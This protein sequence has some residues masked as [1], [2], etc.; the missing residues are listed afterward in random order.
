MDLRLYSRVI[1]RFRYLVLGGL[2]V[3]FALAF[4]SFVSIGSGG[5]KYRER[6]QWVSYTTLFVTQPGFPAGRAVI[7]GVDPNASTPGT[8]TR[9]ADPA[10]FSALAILY[11]QLINSDAVRSVMEKDGPING[12]IEAAPVTTPDGNEALPLVQIAATSDS[13]AA[14]EALAGRTSLAFRDY[15]RAQQ[16]KSSIRPGDRAVATSLKAP[17]TAILVAGRSLTKPV[18]IFLTTLIVVLGLAFVLENLNPKVRV[19]EAEEE[20][21]GLAP[22]ASGQ[23]G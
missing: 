1:W 17:D 21:T 14:A 7:P 13:P 11:A 2:L 18:V 8:G 10:R 4:L 12:K 23:A 19:S 9:F 22:D 16:L 3:G 20:R 6:E 15:L 5:V